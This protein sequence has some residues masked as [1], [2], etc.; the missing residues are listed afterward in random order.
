M[1]GAVNCALCRKLEYPV[2]RGSHW[3][4]SLNINQNLLGKVILVLNRHFEDVTG[5][6]SEEWGALHDD[7][8]RVRSAIDQLFAPDHYNFDFLMNVDPHVHL[9]V[10]P[11]YASSRNWLGEI[12]TDS[13]FGTLFGTEHRRLPDEWMI[14]LAEELRARLSHGSEGHT[15]P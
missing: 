1:A 10:M 12:F 8:G 2:F 5:L 14:A 13:H 6:S 11:R 9:H 7:L 4:V 3:I 15:V